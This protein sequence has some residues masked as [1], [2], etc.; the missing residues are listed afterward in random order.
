MEKTGEVRDCEEGK[1]FGKGGDWILQ[2]TMEN[3]N[4]RGAIMLVINVQVADVNDARQ[5]VH[6][7]ASGQSP[8]GRRAWSTRA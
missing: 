3:S 1:H 5:D 2:L 6:F 4:I 8:L 7:L